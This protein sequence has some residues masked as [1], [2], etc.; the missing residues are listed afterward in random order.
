PRP[1]PRLRTALSLVSGRQKVRMAA[2]A[3]ASSA[4]TL[5]AMTAVLTQLDD[6][7]SASGETPE[8]G[9]IAQ[10]AAG[11]PLV[12]RS[13]DG[14]VYQVSA[15]TRGTASKRGWAEFLLVN[16]SGRPAPVRV[17]VDLF[18]PA[19]AAAGQGCERRAGTRPGHCAV[20][21]Q[22]RIIALVG[23]SGDPTGEGQPLDVQEM[24]D[25]ARYVIRIDN[26]RE[27]ADLLGQD[28]L[29]LYVYQ[30]RF[31]PDGRARELRFP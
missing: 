28:D 11:E 13:A 6:K 17:P 20:R 5:V 2:A 14:F 9:R 16:L 25:G 18:I 7:T 21:S 15:I 24:P 26:E 10:P 23:D 31:F 8:E 3:I 4:L 19:S 22:Q 1:A 29:A 27:F 30:A 12:L